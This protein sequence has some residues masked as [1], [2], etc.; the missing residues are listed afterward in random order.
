MTNLDVLIRNLNCYLAL[1]NQLLDDQYYLW[2]GIL[3]SNCD[4]KSGIFLSG[5]RGP[6]LNF[7]N[8][9]RSRIWEAY[10]LW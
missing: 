2:L 6:P 3:T 8:P 9:K 1:K 7:D 10:M 4:V 5:G